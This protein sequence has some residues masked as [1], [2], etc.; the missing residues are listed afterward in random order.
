M[1]LSLFCDFGG[2]WNVE[3]VCWRRN[4]GVSGQQF[5]EPNHNV[6]ASETQ[7]AHNLDKLQRLQQGAGT[8]QGGRARQKLVRPGRAR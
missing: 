4:F 5:L 6:S 3:G 7:A 1:L 2:W 8:G